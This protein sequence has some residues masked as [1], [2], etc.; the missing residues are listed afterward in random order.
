[1][2]TTEEQKQIASTILNQLGGSRFTSMT[3]AKDFSVIKEGGMVCKIG[4][5]ASS[6]NY[7]KITLNSMD[8]YD[9]EFIRIH[10]TKITT[11]K[12]VTDLYNHM[13]QDVFID[14]TEMYLTL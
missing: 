6:A 12:K 5:N 14:T 4:R 9:M 7:I 3:G 11:K 10:G 2:Y 1:M 13:L 8:L